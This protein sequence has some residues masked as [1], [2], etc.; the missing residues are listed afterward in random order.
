MDQP[1]NPASTEIQ[2]STTPTNAFDTVARD[3]ANAALQAAQV[4]PIVSVGVSATYNTSI[5]KSRVGLNFSSTTKTFNTDLG[6]S[7]VDTTLIPYIRSK[8]IN[9]SAYHLKPN[10]KL[11]AFFD[12][13]KVDAYVTPAYRVVLNKS[14][15]IVGQTKTIIRANS[16]ATVL[17]AKG[18]TIFVTQ[19]NNDAS[20]KIS[21]HL[22]TA[23]TFTWDGISYS[24][25]SVSLPTSL[26][27][28]ENGYV[29]G[30]FVIPSQ[31]FSG[32][33]RSFM[34]CDTPNN[35]NSTTSA[36]FIYYASGLASSK[37]STT[38]ST[39]INQVTINPLLSTTTAKTSGESISPLAV[40]SNDAVKVIHTDVTKP[41]ITTYS[42][43]NGSTVMS[44][45]D[46]FR[47]TF[48]GPVTLDNSNTDP[49]LLTLQNGTVLNS[50]SVLANNI[51]TVTPLLELTQNIVYK[52][53]IPAAYVKDSNGY[54]FDGMTNYQITTYLV[55]PVVVP[56]VP[57]VPDLQV[58]SWT[59]ML[60]ASGTSRL[61]SKIV[62]TFNE[63]I[64]LDVPGTITIRKTSATAAVIETIAIPSSL[65]VLTANQLTVTP[66]TK[67]E[68]ET[69]Y[70]F[71]FS[72]HCVKTADD[73]QWAG[74][75][76]YNFTIQ[77]KASAASGTFTQQVI[78][79]N[80]I[81]QEYKTVA[82]SATRASKIPV[83]TVLSTTTTSTVDKYTKIG[84]YQHGLQVEDYLLDFTTNVGQCGFD[85]TSGFNTPVAIDLFWDDMSVSKCGTSGTAGTL[86]K[87]IF[88]KSFS[89]SRDNVSFFG[90]TMVI[91][92]NPLPTVATP[93]TFRFNKT[94][95]Y[96]KTALLRI[97]KQPTSTKTP[98]TWNQ[99][100]PGSVEDVTEF[101]DIRYQWKDKVSGTEKSEYTTS[102]VWINQEKTNDANGKPIHYFSAVENIKKWNRTGTTSTLPSKPVR[103]HDPQAEQ[104]INTSVLGSIRP[105]DTEKPWINPIVG[106]PSVYMNAWTYKRTVV[107]KNY[108]KTA[109]GIVT[110][111]LCTPSIDMGLSPFTA[112]G[113]YNQSSKFTTTVTP[114]DGITFPHTLAPFQEIYVD[115]TISYP[116]ISFSMDEWTWSAYTNPQNDATYA[117]IHAYNKENW[118][119][120]V[121]EWNKAYGLFTLMFGTPYITTYEVSVGT[122]NNNP[123]TA[124]ESLNLTLKA[125]KQTY[126][127]T[128]LTTTSAV[129]TTLTQDPL[130]QT[131]FVSDTDYPDGYFLSSIDLFFKAKSN[132][133]DV[134]VQL[135]PVDNGLP[136][137]KT[138]IPF[139]ITTLDQSD[140][141]IT[142]YPNPTDPL[143]FT[144]FKFQSP[145]YLSPGAYSYVVISNSKDYTVFTSTIGKFRLDD[146]DVR[147][148][149]TNS[150]GDLFKSSNGTTWL[151][152][153]YQDMCFT[154]NR[155]NFKKTGTATFNS[156]KPPA[157]ISSSYNAFYA[158]SHYNQYEYIIVPIS[159]YS[160]KLYEVS[161]AGVSGLLAPIH[162]GGTVLNGS[163]N[164]QYIATL[165]KNTDIKI[166]YDVYF[167]HGENVTFKNAEA[168]YFYKGTS[169]SG[170]LDIDFIPIALGS[171]YEL[172]TRKLLGSST[173]S[174][175]SKIELSSEDS[176][177]SPVI[178]IKRFS[179]V[180]VRNIINDNTI[181][182]D[183][184]ANTV[185]KYGEYIKTAITDISN[186]V[187]G[188]KMYLVVDSGK[189]SET[190]PIFDGLDTFNGSATLRFIGIT[191][192]GDTELLP[193]GGMAA[194]RYLTRKVE[195][196][197]GF[198]STDISV[199][200][201]AHTPVGS[202]IKVYYKAAFVDG[203]TTLEESVYHE[204]FLA[205]RAPNY[206]GAFVEHKYICDYGD[207]LLPGVRHALPNNG[208][209]N[210]FSIKIVML[211]TNA[212]TV[213]KIR[214]LRVIA[215][216]D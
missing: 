145:I 142:D 49:V 50:T 39:R 191:N 113:Q 187:T 27:S 69:K 211:S 58:M 126:S 107:I 198:E 106:L 174:L 123:N 157:I 20:S 21:S 83:G 44:T 4:P 125:N 9:F 167:S 105:I 146:P 6:E 34:I 116:D 55:P 208:R 163:I 148:T 202:T 72:P 103:P 172:D 149:E 8:S 204:M 63:L 129:V 60:G 37:Q 190:S 32:G 108:S 213:P 51:L 196:A 29:A 18:S 101:A 120:I 185:V 86:D 216:D 114:K 175:Y 186:V 52:V 203:N 2:P 215:L 13:K 77:P 184:V 188:Y 5:T 42:P 11:Y 19:K 68:N 82:T 199:Q 28:D 180:L 35:V 31:T 133:A 94:E 130:A 136:S 104:I 43:I 30:V 10:S 57:V 109:S 206:A 115:V 151:P 207:I 102:E 41:Y 189:T 59:P 135:R 160:D 137:V 134:T 200:C 212:T 78:N 46:P 162:N 119:F 38:L 193:T 36:E 128:T 87:P 144:K 17:F 121:T 92:T 194:A 150:V 73:I 205:E 181:A 143:S 179:N 67:F 164:L 122:Q 14:V 47:F 210:Q 25:V 141:N 127:V 66:T 197:D 54:K 165:E 170:V 15:H 93:R 147:I 168:K 12:G 178:D 56:G 89:D 75:T 45:T 176:I 112:P 64:F 138:T 201:N 140:V 111:I 132:T 62:A 23:D 48:D 158:E 99:I 7:V 76:D 192:N 182:P 152:S 169:N 74:I 71:T 22:K 90:S 33:S 155:A 159:A 156:T 53:V 153:P 118:S 166:P 40:S 117:S 70:Y 183:F 65:V 154:I 85:V 26:N 79:A 81:I 173:E 177:V 97:T 195:L 80:S 24:V 124:I 91:D 16:T 209:F 95:P 161:N 61:T 171:N 214:D 88:S 84:G 1:S 96:P 3:L 139:A 131:F 110:G 98:F 100:L